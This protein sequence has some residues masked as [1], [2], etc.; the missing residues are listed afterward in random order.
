MER[1]IRK[2]K[3]VILVMSGLLAVSLGMNGYTVWHLLHSRPMVVRHFKPVGDTT[4]TSQPVNIAENICSEPSLL[5]LASKKSFTHG[6]TKQQMSLLQN[7]TEDNLPEEFGSW[8]QDDR[9]LFLKH[10]DLVLNELLAEKEF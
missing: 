5:A 8:S 9:R 6:T 1:Q 4:D 10:L 2:F 3:V 7:W